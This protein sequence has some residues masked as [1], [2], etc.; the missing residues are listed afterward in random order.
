LL[1]DAA[2]PSVPTEVARVEEPSSVRLDEERI[3]VERAV[4]VEV[5]RDVEVAER[6]GLPMNQVPLGSG[7]ESAGPEEQL[8]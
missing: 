8:P 7:G 1:E 5:R 6:E 4:V 2:L 3:G